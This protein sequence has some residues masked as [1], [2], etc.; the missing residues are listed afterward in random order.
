MKNSSVFVRLALFGFFLLVQQSASAYWC[1]LNGTGRNSNSTDNV[2][3]AVPSVITPQ[4]GWQILINASSYIYCYGT[5]EISGSVYKDYTVAEA[6]G[7][8]VNPAFFAHSPAIIYQNG[9]NGTSAGQ[10]PP[11]GRIPADST[12]LSWTSPGQSGG[13]PVMVLFYINTATNAVAATYPAGTYLGSVFLRHYNVWGK[14]TYNNFN[15]YSANQMVL[16]Q[17]ISCSTTSNPQNVSLPTVN[18]KSLTGVGTTAGGTSV[19][20]AVKC[21]GTTSVQASFTDANLGTSNQNYLTLGTGSTAAGVGVKLVNNKTG[22]A[23][24]YGAAQTAFNSGA[25]N[26]VTIGQAT[27]GSTLTLPLTASYVQTGTT[28]TPGK[29]KAAV[30]LTFALQ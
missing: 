8:L 1:T 27:A 13:F 11:S 17:L 16:P 28:V 19:T 15:F 2:F 18:T 14:G 7:T 3:V 21:N 4:S 30:T 23:L 12:V 25:T 26:Q 10:T 22:N 6:A 5:Y 9:L 24:T 29:V 20:V